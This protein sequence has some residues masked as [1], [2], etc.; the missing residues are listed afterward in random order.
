MKKLLYKTA[1]FTAPFFILFWVYSTYS[2]KEKGD[3]SRLGYIPKT[4]DY[5]FN[6]LFKKEINEKLNFDLISK[7]DLNKK[8]HYSI[9]TVGDSFSEQGGMSYQNAIDPSLKILHYD[10]FL[11]ENPI[12]TVDGLLNGDVLD[13]L[14]VD[15]IILQSVERSFVQRGVEFKNQ[16][17]I[18]KKSIEKLVAE[19]DQKSKNPEKKEDTEDKFFSKDII[20]FP[21]NN[22]LY[23]FKDKPYGSRIYQVN[24][25]KNLFSLNNNKLLFLD[26]DYSVIPVNNDSNNVKKLNTELNILAKKLKQKGIQLIVLPCPDKFDLYYDYIVNKNDYTRPLFFDL[27]RSLEKDY[28]FVDSKKILQDKIKSTIDVY[29]YD[30]THWSPIATKLV[31]E[32]IEKMIQNSATLK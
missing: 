22:I 4:L 8:N 14:K 20:L 10:R 31:G 28:L 12:E 29:F 30:D 23:H 25:T 17:K 27:F 9:L 11:H 5:D 32:E 24:T 13:N 18:T 26:D 2:S 19:H 15:Y 16:S 21:L 6:V 7:I 1:F 3:L